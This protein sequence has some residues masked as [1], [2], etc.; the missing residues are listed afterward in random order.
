MLQRTMPWIE[1]ISETVYA[2]YLFNSLILVS[3]GELDCNET[4]F[5]KRLASDLELLP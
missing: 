5:K 3:L 1:R 2:I 4:F